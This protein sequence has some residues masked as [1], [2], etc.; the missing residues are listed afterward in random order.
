MSRYLCARTTI[1]HTYYAYVCMYV[2]SHLR[3]MTT[4]QCVCVCVCI[5]VHVH[6]HTR[7]YHMCATRSVY[8]QTI[9]IAPDSSDLIIMCMYNYM[10][11]F[12]LCVCVCVCVCLVESGFCKLSYA[13]YMYM[14]ERYMYTMAICTR[15]FPPF[16]SGGM[17]L[18]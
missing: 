9:I 5:H 3:V 16:Y 18:Y 8:T 13:M 4:S 7:T 12:V 17:I 1:T 14:Q 10:C 15:G 2:Y 11:V 6:T